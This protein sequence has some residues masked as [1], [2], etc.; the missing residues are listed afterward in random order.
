[1]GNICNSRKRMRKYEQHKDLW[2]SIQEFSF[3]NK[4]FKLMCR[5]Q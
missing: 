4:R 2:G 3:D 5:F 1:M